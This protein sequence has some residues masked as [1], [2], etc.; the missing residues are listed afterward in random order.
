[1]SHPT[2]SRFLARELSEQLNWT[3]PLR[4]FVAPLLLPIASP[5]AGVGGGHGVDELVFV[6]S[7]EYRKGLHVFCEAVSRVLRDTGAITHLKVRLTRFGKPPPRK[8]TQASARLDLEVSAGWASPSS[9]GLLG[10]RRAAGQSTLH[11][12]GS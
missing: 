1:M 7:L 11:A 4:T 6:G 12:A 10:W 8:Q 5:A 2:G 9:R 3:L